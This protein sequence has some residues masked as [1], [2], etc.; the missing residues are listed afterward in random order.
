MSTEK[1]EQPTRAK[2]R[3][4]RRNGQVAR[5]K[6]LVSTVLILSLVALP[7]GFPDYFLGHL[8]G[9][10][11]L[12][13][14]LLHLPFRQA[15]ELM[16]EQLLHE[17][18]WLTLPFLL[19]AALAAIVGNLLQTG[20]VFSG[21]S[22]APDL[23]K[24]SPL[25]GVTR[26]FSIRNL[27]DFFKSSLKV[28]LLGALVLG[29]LSEHLGTLLRV[30]SCGIECILPLLGSLMGQLIGVCAV[31]FLAISAADYGLERWQHHKQL[32]MSKEE[33]KREHKEM[34][35]APE[36]KRERRKRH[37][38]MQKGTLRA[39]VRRSSVIIANPTHIAVG[40]R[41]NPGETPLPLVTLK[42]TDEQALL[43][44]RLAE[45]EGIPVLER[46]PLARALFAGSRVEQYIPG[47]LIQPVAE[48]IR[49]LRAQEE[50]A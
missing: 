21:Q 44:R 39:D 11:M 18:L 42:Y 43:V 49:W 23:K 31:G 2:L 41:Y 6:E 19:T 30:S 45:E 13:A 34:E 46:I 10:M 47:E 9:L 40:L 20:F 27:L 35:G 37:R 22:L 14:P 5:S 7:M 38:E 15:L 48:V 24:V 50:I 12:P 4:A 3:D 1:T 32:R 26:V 8:R 17:L 36:L 33:V 28:L 25:E 16:L 29:L